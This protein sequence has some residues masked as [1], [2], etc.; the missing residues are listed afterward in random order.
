MK[1]LLQFL[2]LTTALSVLAVVVLTAGA[3]AKKAKATPD[4]GTAHDAGAAV[5]RRLEYFPATK[6]GPMPVEIGE[7]PPQQAAPNE[8]KKK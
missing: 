8:V 5:R 4:A 3:P 1:R 7:A 2:S 6:A